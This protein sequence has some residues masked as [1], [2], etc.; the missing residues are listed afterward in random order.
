MNMSS[1]TRALD[2]IKVG[3]DVLVSFQVETIF[4]SDSDG[5]PLKKIYTIRQCNRLG[6]KGC[7]FVGKKRPL[8]I[9]KSLCPNCLIAEEY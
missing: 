1:E 7:G 5:S 6:A 4:R 2:C 9:D 3:G 8:P